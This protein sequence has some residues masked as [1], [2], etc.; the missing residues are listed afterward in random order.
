M[1]DTLLS[2]LIEQSSPRFRL[3][4]LSHDTGIQ[5][6]PEHA[7]HLPLG[8]DHVLKRIRL[9]LWA[10]RQALNYHRPIRLAHRPFQQWLHAI[11][12]ACK[13]PFYYSLIRCNNI[14]LLYN[15]NQHSISVPIPF[16]QTVWDINHRIHSY[17]PE[18]SYTRFGFEALDKEF[19]GNLSRASYVV[20]GTHVG[21]NQL[22]QM[23]GISPTKT[24][25]IPFPTPSLPTFSTTT[26]PIPDHHPFLFYPARLWPHKNHAVI[27][28]ALVLLKQQYHLEFNFVSVGADSGN[29][30]YLQD[31]AAELNISNQVY[32]LGEVD[33]NTLSALYR[34]AFAL[35]FAS[36]AGPDNLP[37][38]EAMALGCP[39]IVAAN[40]GT[41]EQ[42][43][44]SVLT[45]S[46]YN[47]ND[48][49][50]TIRHL[51]A[52]SSLRD[53]LIR[54]GYHLAAR[55]TPLAYVRMVLDI[56]EEFHA[57]ARNWQRCDST[58]I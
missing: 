30:V 55:R 18:F 7:I 3:F 56:F 2:L 54:K 8:S 4:V 22:V 36:A 39:A 41:Q 40:E 32:F 52:N 38:L 53:S 33:D 44:D 46:P 11:A 9:R 42:F 16:I 47:A 10:F 26:I 57:V 19:L 20:T 34:R 14:R 13:E 51:A 37:P 49:A 24:R 12:S 25:V 58:F 45:F 29:L 27:L 43:E 17:F 31:L 48:L 21:A 1:Q 5:A 35:I 23:V 15:L 28:H 6:L 50:Q